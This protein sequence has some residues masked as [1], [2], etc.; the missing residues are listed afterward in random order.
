VEPRALQQRLHLL[1]PPPH[2]TRVLRL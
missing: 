1:M 2:H